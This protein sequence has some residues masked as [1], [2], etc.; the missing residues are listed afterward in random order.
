MALLELVLFVLDVLLQLLDSELTGVDLL[1][2]LMNHIVQPDRGVLELDLL[3]LQ[4]PAVGG[5]V[6]ELAVEEVDLLVPHQAN[7]RIIEATAKYAGVPMDKVFVNVDKYGNMSSATV[8]VAFDEA[9]EQGRISEGSNVVTVAF[10][11]GLTWGAM[12]IRM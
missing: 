3:P 9:R 4:D 10:G 8:P 2:S 5:L 12:A 6:L 1:F 7:I 11:A